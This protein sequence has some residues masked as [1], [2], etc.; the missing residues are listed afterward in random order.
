MAWW[1]T[2]PIHEGGGSLE[3]QEGHLW[4]ATPQEGLNP[5]RGKIHCLVEKTEPVL[6]PKP[7]MRAGVVYGLSQRLQ[8][9][10][11]ST[12]FYKKAYL[13]EISCE[14]ACLCEGASCQ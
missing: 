13:L 7:P 1:K 4:Q 14:A 12:H 2:K 8:S 6:S 11:P 5:C 10:L 3:N 9:Q